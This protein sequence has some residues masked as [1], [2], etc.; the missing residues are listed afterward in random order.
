LAK[1]AGFTVRGHKNTTSAP[2]WNMSIRNTLKMDALTK[3]RSILEIF[4][5]SNIL[6]LGFFTLIDLT[7]M[8]VRIPTS[9]QQLVA[10]R[11]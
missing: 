11:L 1:E 6:S 9:T 10:V 2:A 8:I 4:N 7:L 5:Y 3:H